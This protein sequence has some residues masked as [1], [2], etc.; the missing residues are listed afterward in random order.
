M[1]NL[2]GLGMRY[3]SLQLRKIVVQQISQNARLV[4]V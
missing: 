1:P 2:F 4:V 3:F